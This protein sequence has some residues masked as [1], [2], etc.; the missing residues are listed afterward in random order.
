MA[1]AYPLDRARAWC[2]H[3][4]APM[5][6]VRTPAG[7]TLAE[8]D[9]LRFAVGSDTIVRPPRPS[10]L[11]RKHLVNRCERATPE[12]VQIAAANVILRGH[13][14]YMLSPEQRSAEHDAVDAV[15][16]D[17]AAVHMVLQL[18]YFKAKRQFFNFYRFGALGIFY[19]FE[20]PRARARSSRS[21]T[22]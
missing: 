20:G 6:S 19:H 18:G 13:L 21:F 11:I 15:H 9:H 3:A 8:S 1:R 14:G 10:A 16:T 12:L 17:A 5:H 7:I 22:D 2:P 4:E